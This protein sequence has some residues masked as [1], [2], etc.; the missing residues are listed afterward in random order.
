M[1]RASIC[2][3]RGTFSFFI[4]VLFIFILV[5]DV[6]FLINT[7]HLWMNAPQ[8]SIDL[9]FL[10]ALK[11][12]LE[13][14]VTS[15]S[16]ATS[17]KELNDFV[18]QNPDTPAAILVQ[19][20]RQ[21]LHTSPSA[22]VQ[23]RK[24]CIRHTKDNICFGGYAHYSQHP[25]HTAHEI[26]TVL[27]E[28]DPQMNIYNLTHYPNGRQHNGLGTNMACIPLT[29]AGFA[30][31]KDPNNVVVELGPFLGLSTKCIAVGMR[32][33]GVKE[34]TLFVYDTFSGLMNFRAIQR[35]HPWLKDEHPEYTQQNDNFHFLW[36]YGV[37]PT[38]PTVISRQGF[39]SKET[40]NPEALGHRPVALI[41]I[42][43][44]KSN[45]HLQQQLAGL[46][47]LTK[48]SIL[49][50]MDFEFVREHIVL[51]YACLRENYLLPVYLSWSL[52]H[53]MWIVTDDVDLADP[54]HYQC[55]D[56][57]KTNKDGRSRVVDLAMRDLLML[58]G[59]TDGATVIEA[60]ASVRNPLSEKIASVLR[61]S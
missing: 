57:Y 42:D 35:M 8:I 43:S 36:E 46:G 50:M 41:S 31:T 14:V 39:I 6:V 38:F 48:G 16:P 55:Y 13:S 56:E 29:L 11:N 12:T 51:F 47:P 44:A 30:A 7:R 58:S 22:E 40:L 49:M 60:F 10:P 1:T 28:D 24:A 17:L 20:L 54:K 27:W 52:E 4:R 37:K 2:S 18:Y 3:L 19:L 25:D 34:N 9:D 32:K 21:H 15:Q 23:R 59:L 45:Q 26:P 33:N 53:W 5:A 61:N